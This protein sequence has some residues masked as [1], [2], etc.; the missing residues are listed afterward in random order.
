MNS[1]PAVAIAGGGIIGM[2]IAWRLAQGGAAVTVFDSGRIGNEASWAGAGMLAPGGEFRTPTLWSALAAESLSLYPDF[3]EEL[4]N[5]SGVSVD[6]RK[7][8]AFD[9]AF[10]EQEATALRIRAEEQAGMGIYSEQFPAARIPGIRNGAVAAQYYPDDSVVNPREVLRALRVCCESAGV[11]TR[12]FEAVREIE[13]PE[14]VN[15]QRFDSVV[16]AAGAWSSSIPVRVGGVNAALPKSIP[17][18]GH[19]I[20]FDEH[21]GLCD[22]MVRHGS[23][24]LL[25]RN[26]NLVIAG[27]STERQGFDRTLDGS[28]TQEL[29]RQA[30]QLIP[31]LEDLRY[32]AWNGFRP[33]SETDEPV[34]GRLV[35][36]AIWL[37]YGHY[38][39]GILLAPAT[40]KG[41]ARE[42]LAAEA[43]PANSQ[44]D[45]LLPAAYR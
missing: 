14:T 41:V 16:L 2:S 4:S 45:S 17:I 18:R 27:A 44:M 10:S 36:S 1:D 21:T 43:M 8:G 6:F 15:G 39:N 22:A 38:R 5:Q 11:Q 7:C 20:A 35:N 26:G 29:A 13:V 33:G 12:E 24:Y 30:G 23:T 32:V 3:V 42:I 37:A 28:A 25:R 31:A 40:A 19:L 34:I 9:V